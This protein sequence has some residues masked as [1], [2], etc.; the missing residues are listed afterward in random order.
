MSYVVVGL[1]FATT[2]TLT[3]G[4]DLVLATGVV[5]RVVDLIFAAA[6]CAGVVGLFPTAIMIR[7]T[8]HDLS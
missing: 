8:W 6:V 4:H 2:M 3:S 1:L 5:R 7:S